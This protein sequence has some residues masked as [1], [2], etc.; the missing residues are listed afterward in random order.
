MTRHETTDARICIVTGSHLCRNPRVVKEADALSGAGYDVTVL[1]PVF[2]DDLRSEDEQ[3]MAGAD[4]THRVSVDLRTPISGTW[5]RLRRR[6]G[7]EL[8]RRGWDVADALGYG[9]RRTLRRARHQNADLYIGHEE[10]GTWVVWQLERDGARVGVDFED[11]HSRD[12]LPQDR[13]QRPVTLLERIERDLLHR[14]V[15]ATTTSEVMAQAM[16]DAYDAPAPTVLYNAFPWTDREILDDERRDRDGSG[17]VSLHWVSQTIGPGRGLDT[18]C[19]ALQVVDTPL[20]VHLRG[21]CRPDYRQKLSKMFP[22]DRGH[23][24]HTHGLV[25]PSVVL[26]R[27]AE[28]DIGLAL[29][30]LRPDNKLYTVSNKI[31]HYLLGGLAVVA[32][33]TEGQREVATRSGRAV[34][35]C[36][37]DD[38]DEMAHQIS[39]LLNTEKELDRAQNDALEAARDRFCWEQQVPRLLTSVARALR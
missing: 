5:A 32:T 34:R 8:T 14:S 16:A 4:W 31:L 28:H 21:E 18:L 3:L 7:T 22:D 10:V 11:W 23:T 25:S 24:L 15:H 6:V 37:S 12:L 26:S 27:I 20:H 38:A 1:G 9:V 2:G 30:P 29:E 36:P 33:D 13:A 35:L 19:Q 17:R 39:E